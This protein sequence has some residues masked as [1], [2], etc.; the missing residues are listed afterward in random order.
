LEE[1]HRK[2]IN[3]KTLVLTNTIDQTDLTDR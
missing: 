2:K 1:S 3:M